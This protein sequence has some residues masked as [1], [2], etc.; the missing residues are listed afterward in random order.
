MRRAVLASLIL[1]ALT[2]IALGQ[3]TEPYATDKVFPVVLVDATDGYTPETEKKAADTTITYCNITDGNATSSYTDD[4]TLWDEVGDGTG[5]YKL[6]IGASE[7]S[8][9]GK[10]YLVKVVV[11]GCRTARFWVDTRRND[12]NLTATNERGLLAPIDPN[13][14][15]EVTMVDFPSDA[16]VMTTDDVETAVQTA[17]TA[18]GYT[19]PRAAY[20]DYNPTMATAV[21]EVN[22]IAALWATG[23][24]AKT[25]LFGEDA[26]GVTEDDSVPIALTADD[27]A[28][29]SA[30]VWSVV[31]G[32]DANF[33]DPTKA[34][35]LLRK[36]RGVGLE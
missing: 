12:P 25:L 36:L 6:T 27:A 13:G 18:Q 16:N 26:N 10:R 33:L 9:M 4:D 31:Y 30:A 32:S 35:Y 24:L 23:T 14:R 29:I 22:D 3:F 28:A 11:S 1:V 7:F 20:L 19:I 8:A 15:P 5:E 2:A 17:M 34:G 21:N